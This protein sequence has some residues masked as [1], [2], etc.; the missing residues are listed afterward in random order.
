M[1][2][3][4]RS[5]E[6]S[7]LGSTQQSSL[8]ISRRLLSDFEYESEDDGGAADS[9]SPITQPNPP[10]ALPQQSITVL[11]NQQLA[12]NY[13]NTLNSLQALNSHG[14]LGRYFIK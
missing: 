3:M 10:P 11:Q 5:H 9:S 14:S 6:S 12:T 7:N 8:N 2:Q 1:R 13:L 4:H